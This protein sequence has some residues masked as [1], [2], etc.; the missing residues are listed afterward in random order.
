[1]AL[2]AVYAELCKLRETLTDADLD[3]AYRRLLEGKTVAIVGPARTLLGKKQGAFIDAHDLVVR[4]NEAFEQFPIPPAL[5][6]DIGTRADILYCNQSIL[7]N[8][9]WRRPRSD[10]NRLIGQFES[11]GVK[12]VACTNNS[13]S[14]TRTGEP[15]ETCSASDA[16]TI[17]D[18]SAFFSR[19]HSRTAVRVVYAAAERLVRWL[20]GNWPRTG[21]V[22]IVDV[23]CFPVGHVRIFGMTFYH[24]GGHLLIPPTAELHPLK[25]R[26]GSWARSP[27][28]IGHD[29][30]LELEIMRLLIR[31][32]GDMV[33]VDEDLAALLNAS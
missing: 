27:S 18:L 14:Y 31:C 25:N 26:D 12:Y 2:E 28:G 23:L 7:K 20:N 30:Y 24:G 6:E 1:M 9:I 5:A 19:H 16:R 10:R 32:F 11:A 15:G 13:L 22:G 8:R 29:S 33:E 4:F 3:P 17:S 21:L